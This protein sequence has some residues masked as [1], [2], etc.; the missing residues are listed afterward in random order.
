LPN[1]PIANVHSQ[2][3]QGYDENYDAAKKGGH[4]AGVARRAFEEEHGRKV[5][6]AKSYLE[7]R[8]KLQTG[9]EPSEPD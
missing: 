8:K 4:A 2:D 7:E 1:K 9:E 3:A 5:I 6:S